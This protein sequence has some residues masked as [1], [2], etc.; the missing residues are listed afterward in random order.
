MTQKPAP[1]TLSQLW[2]SIET[3]W[4]NIA[5]E[6]FQQLVDSMPRRVTAL[7]RAKGGPTRY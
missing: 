2:A 7:R 4:L 5:A 3:A 1:S 6:D